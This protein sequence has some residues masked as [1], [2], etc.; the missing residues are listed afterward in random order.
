MTLPIIMATGTFPRE[1]LD[2]HPWLQIDAPLLKPHTFD[3]LL[4]TMKKILLQQIE[5]SPRKD[6]SVVER[7][8]GRRTTI[9]LDLSAPHV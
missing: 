1:E 4:G 8:Y 2:R 9:F 7:G 5:H 3:E 6:D